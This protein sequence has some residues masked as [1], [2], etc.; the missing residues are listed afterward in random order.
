[1]LISFISD[2]KNCWKRKNVKVEL[3]GS[4]SYKVTVEGSSKE[5][6]IICAV[7]DV[8]CLLAFLSQ[9][10]NDGTPVFEVPTEPKNHNPRNRVRLVLD[11]II[12]PM[13]K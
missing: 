5:E 8:Y 6:N 10:F 12:L 7:P 13:I 2:G 4:S 11:K 1:M 9:L 3:E